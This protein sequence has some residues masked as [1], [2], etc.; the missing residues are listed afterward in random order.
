MQVGRDPQMA[1]LVLT[2]Q[3]EQTFYDAGGLADGR[4]VLL[5]WT[6]DGNGMPSKTV[7]H[8]FEVNIPR[9]LQGPVIQ[10][11]PHYVST[12]LKRTSFSSA[13]ARGLQKV[14][15]SYASLIGL[16]SSRPTRKTGHAG[17]P[18]WPG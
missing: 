10:L 3:T 1:Q 8:P 2:H 18:A 17:E 12:G 13:T 6:L 7:L 9:R 5:A 14:V 16:D 4:Y 11:A 15:H